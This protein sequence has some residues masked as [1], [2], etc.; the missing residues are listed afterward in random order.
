M[1][2]Q[3]GEPAGNDLEPILGRIDSLPQGLVLGFKLD[4]SLASL[5]ELRT[6]HHAAVGPGLLQLALRFQGPPAPP[7]ELFGEMMDHLLELVEGF[8][9]G[10]L[11]VV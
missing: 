7:G 6:R 9:V 2:F 4:H 10:A 8:L 5:G 11:V 1:L 3:E